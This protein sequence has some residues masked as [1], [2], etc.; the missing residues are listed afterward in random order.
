MSMHILE[1]DNKMLKSLVDHLH[2]LQEFNV[3]LSQHLPTE[4]VKHCQV[5]KFEKNCL[6]VMVD[7]GHWATQ[8]RFNIPDLMNSLREIPKLK[9]LNGIICK[10]R[11]QASVGRSSHAVKT[12]KVATMSPDTAADVL[13]IAKSIKDDKIRKILE[14]IAGNSDSV[15]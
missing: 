2:E 5:V 8:L 6:F 7:N 14:R 11:P 12:R 15:D 3:L 4:I 1:H 9:N 13:E 10:T